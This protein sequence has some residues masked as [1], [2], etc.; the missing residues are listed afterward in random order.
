MFPSYVSHPFFTTQISIHSVQ[1]VIRRASWLVQWLRICLSKQGT[2]VASL[3]REDP[4]CC[5]AAKPVS[6]S[7]CS[8]ALGPVHHDEKQQG[9]DPSPQL[10]KALVLQQRPRAA[11]NKCINLFLSNFGVI[12]CGNTHRP[13]IEQPLFTCHQ[14]RH[15]KG[16]GHHYGLHPGWEE[17]SFRSQ[18]RSKKWGGV[19]CNLRRCGWRGTLG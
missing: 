2:Q 15:T 1:E 9:A 11:K 18:M 19:R 4:T 8:C 14:Q 3:S 13:S 16:T 7:Y 5:G 10:E 17:K 6:H 12:F